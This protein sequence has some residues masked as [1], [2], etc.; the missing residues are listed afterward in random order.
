MTG[1]VKE[2][3]YVWGLHL[4]ISVTFVVQWGVMMPYF[5]ANEPRGFRYGLVLGL[6]NVSSW[7]C[8]WSA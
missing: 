7:A 8:L 3:F 5:Y 2:W 6:L 1:P 4:I